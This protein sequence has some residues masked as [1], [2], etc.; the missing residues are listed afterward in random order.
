MKRGIVVIILCLLSIVPIS[1][2]AR[3]YGTVYDLDLSVAR[4]AIV[5]INSVPEQT[6]VAKN[7]EFSFEVP[8][9]IYQINAVYEADYSYSSSENI[10]VVREGEFVIDILLSADLSD[11]EDL[12]T[13]QVDVE[14]PE[15]DN[16]SILWWPYVLIILLVIAIVFHVL[17]T[18]KNKKA[19]VNTEEE[20]GED[21][22]SEVIAFIKEK[23]GRV[24]Q[25]EIR[26]Q[27]PVSEA[28]IS[29]VLTE[30]EHKK[31][32]TKIKKS[33]GNVIILNQS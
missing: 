3:V 21:L 9:G 12:L 25:K 14:I 6:M 31:M 17:A 32:I 27:F 33:K 19:V 30:L 23:E 20:I 24:T 18:K 16:G 15:F 8:L 5:T 4:N 10:T 26:R 11:E 1:Y 28:K 29:L 7:G 13:E 2:A 22:S